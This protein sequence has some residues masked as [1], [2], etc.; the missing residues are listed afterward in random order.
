MVL[1]QCD[2]RTLFSVLYDL[3]DIL[4]DSNL[5]CDRRVNITRS[6]IHWIPNRPKEVRTEV[7]PEMKT[8]PH[9]KKTLKKEYQDRDWLYD[10]YWIQMKSIPQIAKSVNTSTTTISSWM[11][12]FQIPCRGHK[13]AIYLSLKKRLKDG[14]IKSLLLKEEK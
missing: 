12:K 4:S 2:L 6:V 14:K 10:Q 9:C 5:F 11:I 13:Q 1:H 8:C 3:R 7:S